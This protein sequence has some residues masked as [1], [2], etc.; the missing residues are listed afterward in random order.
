MER[1]I[2]ASRQAEHLAIRTKRTF[3][4]YAASIQY[5]KVGSTD[6]KEFLSTAVQTLIRNINQNMGDERK[7]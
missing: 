2:T 5:G 6:T 7:S 4:Q 1:I 3:L